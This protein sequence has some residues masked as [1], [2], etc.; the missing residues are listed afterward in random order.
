M[1]N[2]ENL[3]APIVCNM[4]GRTG[5]P[6]MNQF[7]V[8]MPDGCLFQSYKSRICYYNVE[9][10][11]LYFGSNWNYSRT[12]SKYLAQFLRVYAP[13][14]YARIMSYGKRTLAGDIQQAIT[15]GVVMFVSEW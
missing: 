12:T 4:I 15:D 13:R 7:V 5:K 14:W 10:N 1:E 8:M 11:K 2:V 9:E 3:E 6:V